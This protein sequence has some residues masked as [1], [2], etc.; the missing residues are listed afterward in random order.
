MA[1]GGSVEA[2]G[3]R[4]MAEAGAVPR[5]VQLRK[6]VEQQMRILAKTTDPEERK[7]QLRKLAD[8]QLRLGNRQKKMCPHPTFL[9]IPVQSVQR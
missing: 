4:I 9:P 2:V 7:A 6:D 3:F 8:L 1:G 5:E